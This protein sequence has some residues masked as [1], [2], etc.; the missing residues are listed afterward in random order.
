ML[1]PPAQAL[2]AESERSAQVA[3]E[4]AS[5][6]RTTISVA[7]RL[8]TIQTADTI[9]VVENGRIIESGSH[10]E[11]LA[12]NGRYVDLVKPQL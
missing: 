8:S 11:L 10:T 6:G 3:L 7:H 9:H 5:Q 4:Q 2:D 12:R 1:I